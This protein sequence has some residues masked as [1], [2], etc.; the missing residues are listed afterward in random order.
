MNEDCQNN[1]NGYQ[2]KTAPSNKEPHS[3]YRCKAR[4]YAA[5]AYAL[6]RPAKAAGRDSEKFKR[7]IKLLETANKYAEMARS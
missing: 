7:Y 4:D 1:F 3:F 2:I 6:E 5:V